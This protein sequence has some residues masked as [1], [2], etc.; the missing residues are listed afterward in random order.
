[1][2]REALVI[3]LVLMAVGMVVGGAVEKAEIGY[4]IAKHFHWGEGGTVAAEGAGGG[5]GAAIG[6]DVG[7][8][9][10]RWLGGVIGSSLGGPIGGYIGAAI[11]GAIGA[12]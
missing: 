8:Y 7:K 5:I 2:W 12:Y 6:Y 4:R 9:V 1:M 10:G 3:G 11:G